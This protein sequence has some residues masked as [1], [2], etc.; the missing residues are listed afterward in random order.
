MPIQEFL[1]EEIDWL[2]IYLSIDNAIVQDECMQ[3]Y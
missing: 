3:K 1:K 2:E